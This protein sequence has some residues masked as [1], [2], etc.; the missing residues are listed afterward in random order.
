MLL[1]E[2][3]SEGIS[4][5]F[6]VAIEGESRVTGTEAYFRVLETPEKPLLTKLRAMDPGGF[7]DFCANILSNLGA[8]ATRVGGSND[9]GVDF[10]ALSLQLGEKVKFAPRVSKA[11]VIGQ[12]KRYKEGSNIT[13]TMLREFV[14][15][16]ILRANELRESNRFDAGV[17]TP[18]I[19]AYWTTSDFHYEARKYAR[20]MGMWYLNGL[21]LTQL[22]MRAGLKID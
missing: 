18:V 20:A 3:Q 16:A 12:A 19:Y 10:I 4:P 2:E 5:R 17:L 11:L 15:G 9:N 14:G 1:A 6:E 8:K 21:G 7:E 22:A 13:P